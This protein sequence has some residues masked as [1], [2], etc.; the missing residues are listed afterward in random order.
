MAKQIS[1]LT[2]M[3]GLH[4]AVEPMIDIDMVWNTEK[5]ARFCEDIRETWDDPEDFCDLGGGEVILPFGEVYKKGKDHLLYI[6]KRV[7]EQN[8]RK[9]V[10]Q[11]A[12]DDLW[13]KIWEAASEYNVI[14]DL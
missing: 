11:K 12:L 4:G 3:D 5:T 10:A 7:D 13:Q 8:N 2:R 6:L 1:P 9:S 14:Y